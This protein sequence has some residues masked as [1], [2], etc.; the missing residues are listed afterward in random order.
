MPGEND[1]GQRLNRSEGLKKAEKGKEKTPSVKSRKLRILG[2][3]EKRKVQSTW[4]TG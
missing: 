3:A 2:D 4:E 1:S